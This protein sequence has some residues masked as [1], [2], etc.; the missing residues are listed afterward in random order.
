MRDYIYIPRSRETAERHLR[1]ALRGGV[2]G[3]PK[4]DFLK[5]YCSLAYLYPGFHPDCIDDWDG[6]KAVLRIAREAWRRAGAAQLTDNELYPYQATKAAIAR[7][8]AE[9][10]AEE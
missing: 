9:A 2:R 4:R 6:P 1:S 5:A 8:R 10:R 7:A 3:V